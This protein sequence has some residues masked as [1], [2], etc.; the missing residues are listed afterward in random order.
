MLDLYLQED[1]KSPLTGKIGKVLGRGDKQL[2]SKKF[3]IVLAILAAVVL[4]AYVLG[5]VN[6]NTSDTIR[7]SAYNTRK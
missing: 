5:E 3:N 6:P 7:G 1:S 4:W 2:K